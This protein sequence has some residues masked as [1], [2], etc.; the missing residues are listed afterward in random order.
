MFTCI[1]SKKIKHFCPIWY[2]KAFTTKNPRQKQDIIT[3]SIHIIQPI[4]K[5]HWC[6]SL[7]SCDAEKAF[8]RLLERMGFN[9][10]FFKYLQSLSNGLFW[11]NKNWKIINPLTFLLGQN[12]QKN[13]QFILQFIFNWGTCKTRTNVKFLKRKRIVD[14]Q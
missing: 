2:M 7:V 10:Q 14:S 5:Q 9:N 12:K 6:A 11:K 4:D 1:L 3:Y 13:L 8:V